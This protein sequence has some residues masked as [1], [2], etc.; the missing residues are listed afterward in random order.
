MS[1]EQGLILLNLAVTIG[2]YWRTRRV[3]VFKETS[4]LG[5]VA[6]RLKSR[7]APK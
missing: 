5:G 4:K 1:I 3:I 7:K 2:L 6:Y